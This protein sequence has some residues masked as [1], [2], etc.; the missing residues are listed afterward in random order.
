V[1]GAG[2]S[3]EVVGLAIR[4]AL[5]P[6]PANGAGLRVGTGAT[7]TVTNVAVENPAFGVRAD[8]AA[9]NAS[10]M[11]VVSATGTGV[12]LDRGSRAELRDV[13][14]HDGYQ[15][16]V[17]IASHVQVTNALVQRHRATG[18]I[19][20]GPVDTTGG[21]M[22]CGPAGPMMVGAGGWD[23]FSN[24]ASLANASAAF[25][26]LGDAT[27]HMQGARLELSG[28]RTPSDMT[29]GPAY[30]L[31]VAGGATV[32]LD[33]D[34]STDAD[35]GH[36]TSLVANNRAGVLVAGSGTSVSIRGA[37]VGSNSGPGVFVQGRATLAEISYS[38]VDGNSG[39]GLGVVSGASASLVTC[40][41]FHNTHTAVLTDVGG[42][43]FTAGDGLSISAGSGATMTRGNLFTGQQR[44]AA[45]FTNAMGT[46]EGNRGSDNRYGIGAY[47]SP[48][49][50][51]S[52][53]NT[54][55]ARET[56]PA[57]VPPVVD[58]PLP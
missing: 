48:M 50:T 5:P 41:G 7:V 20:D 9:V 27:R 3:V 42:V 39:V 52:A 31:Y 44:F 4:F 26:V 19:L 12:F 14:L 22:A 58:R 6:M 23:C 2:T 56:S 46:V 53:T 35:Q 43:T 51:V 24:V 33:P 32:L 1:T 47:L 55:D 38:L 49:L 13:Y 45:V 16:L 54:V 10:R 11:T 17:A 15:G 34:L 8:G 36:G 57:A 30:G 28:T 18:I 21:A 37:L 29:N 40:N 25:S